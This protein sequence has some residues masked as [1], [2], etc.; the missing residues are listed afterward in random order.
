L[1]KS[2]QIVGVFWGEFTRR[3]PAANAQNNRELLELYASG[4]IRPHVS[5]HYPLERGGEAIQRLADR[6]GQGK[7]VVTV[8]S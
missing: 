8:A 1:L 6:K 4:R 3:D 5:E 7:L 2:C